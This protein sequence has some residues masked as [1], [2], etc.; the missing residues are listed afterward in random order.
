MSWTMPLHLSSSTKFFIG[1]LLFF[2]LDL[3]YKGSIFLP[4]GKYAANGT[5]SGSQGPVFW[6]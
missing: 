3:I 5:F 2:I 4:H 6:L 1:M